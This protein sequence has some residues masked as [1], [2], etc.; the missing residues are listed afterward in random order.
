MRKSIHRRTRKRSIHKKYNRKSRV[1]KKTRNN[2]GYVGGGGGCSK[3]GDVAYCPVY[4]QWW[5]QNDSPDAD[6][7]YS[8]TEYQDCKM[9]EWLSDKYERFEFNYRPSRRTSSLDSIFMKEGTR[10][11]FNFQDM[12]VTDLAINLTNKI[13]KTQS[14]EPSPLPEDAFCVSPVSSPAPHPSYG[15]VMGNLAKYPIYDPSKH[16]SK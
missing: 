7:R 10:L 3:G 6:G 1:S 4:T 15:Q 13:K 5:R 16:P 2:K 14:N 8:W 11:Q 12:T 9:V